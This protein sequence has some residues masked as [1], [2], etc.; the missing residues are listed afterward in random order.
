MAQH[1]HRSHYIKGKGVRLLPSSKVVKR[2]KKEDKDEGGGRGSYRRPM[3]DFDKSTE[4]ISNGRREQINEDGME[5]Q[6]ST[7]IG[8]PH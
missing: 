8:N 6:G 3:N 4:V 1:L 5:P 7:L 2:K